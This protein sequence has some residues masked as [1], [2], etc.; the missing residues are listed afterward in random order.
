MQLWNIEYENQPADAHTAGP[1]GGHGIAGVV[2]YVI[3]GS[4]E[5]TSIRVRYNRQSDAMI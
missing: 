3:I 2:T 4:R 1:G 5:E